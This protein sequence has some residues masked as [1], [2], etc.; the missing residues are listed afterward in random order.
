VNRA[1]AE[2]FFPNENPISKTFETDP[3]DVNGPIQIAGIAAETRYAD[4]R[5]ETPPTFYVLYVQAVKR[6]GAHDG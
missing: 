4:L 1:L 2:K 3:E 5:S 6:T